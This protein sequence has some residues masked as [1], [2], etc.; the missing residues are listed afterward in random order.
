MKNNAD[1]AKWKNFSK[2][3][4]FCLFFE[5]VEDN[6]RMAMPHAHRMTHHCTAHHPLTDVTCDAH[7]ANCDAHVAH[8]EWRTRDA[9][10]APT[11]TAASAP[12]PMCARARGVRWARPMRARAF[13][14]RARKKKKKKKKKQ[15]PRLKLFEEL[16]VVFDEINFFFLVLFFLLRSVY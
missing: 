10:A 11:R 12:R 14:V 1:D 9:A 3:Q 7:V 13:N 6:V 16:Y 15:A 2:I 5:P 8:C 4:K